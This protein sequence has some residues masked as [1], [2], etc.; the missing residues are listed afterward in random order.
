MDSMT[1]VQTWIEGKSFLGIAAGDWLLAIFSSCSFFVGALLTRKFIVM[2][3]ERRAKGSKTRV[4]NT[5]AELTVEIRTGILAAFSLVL[6]VQLLNPSGGWG[7]LVGHLLFII[8]AF[9]FGLLLH[10]VVAIWKRD[11]LVKRA[12]ANSVMATLISSF[13]H[14]VV[15]IVVALAILENAGINIT[16]LVASLGIG[17]VAIALAVQAI[18]GDLFAAISIAV[19][20][21]F[22]VGDSITAGDTTGTV[23]KIGLKSTHIRSVS[24]ELV[25]CSNTDLLKR[26]IQNFQRMSERRAVFRFN[27]HYRTPLDVAEKVPSLVQETIEDIPNTKFGRAHLVKLE[28][29]SME[30]EVVY[31]VLNADYQNYMDVQQTINFSILKHLS[32]LEI[33]IAL[34]DGNRATYFSIPIASSPATFVMPERRMRH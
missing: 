22:Q 4:F 2:K 31:Y 3:L 17:G 8:A 28:R 10:R 15:W 23:E 5:L 16:T 29:S 11:H 20:K 1:A 32:E 14:A 24:G 12:A 6:G 21:P 7:R 18:L 27:L 19:D 26:T 9:Q 13:L 33:D 34:P 25:I 30:F